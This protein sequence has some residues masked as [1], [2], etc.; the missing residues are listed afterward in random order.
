MGEA[1]R[2][3]TFEERKAAAL[4]RKVEEE[5]MDGFF[6]NDPIVTRPG[7]SVIDAVERARL[8]HT[9]VRPRTRS[10][11][12]KESLADAIAVADFLVGGKIN[13]R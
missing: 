3:G 7:E 1:K 12:H 8:D 13:G 2:R 4:E 11:L 10:E 9:V 5:L 6:E